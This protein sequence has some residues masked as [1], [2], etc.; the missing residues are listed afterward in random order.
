MSRTHFACLALLLAFAAN[1]VHA[2]PI[3]TVAPLGLNGGNREWL[4]SIAPDASLFNNNPPNG[5]GGSLA[6]E[7]A[8]SIDDPTDLLSV[9]I[10]DPA[11]W[12]LAN[13]GNNPYTGGITDGIYIDLINDRSF[14]AYGSTYFTTG[15]SKSF[16][17]ITTAGS[18]ATTLRYGVAASG[19]P[20]NGARIAQAGQNFDGYTG[21]VSIPEPGA[22]VL[23][24]VAA[25]AVALPRRK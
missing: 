24:L 18:G 2:A 10:A 23:A 4:V 1:A 7:L 25:V 16:L 3:M 14:A 15:T 20:V 5:V 13:P 11:S 6:V 12:P 8:F 9:A 17:K 19:N 21:I 22:I